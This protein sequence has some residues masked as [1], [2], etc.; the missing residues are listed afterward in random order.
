[1]TGIAEGDQ[2]F[3]RPARW[4]N[5]ITDWF[6]CTLP[7]AIQLAVDTKKWRRIAGCG[8]TSLALWISQNYSN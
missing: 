3:E 4:S 8:I 6:G 1:M 5:D 7:E 2:P